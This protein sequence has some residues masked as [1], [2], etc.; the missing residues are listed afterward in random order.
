[1]SKIEQNHRLAHPTATRKVTAPRTNKTEE[2][3]TDHYTPS[4]MAALP[5]DLGRQL[6]RL[7][8]PQNP[9]PALGPDDHPTVFFTL[10]SGQ[11]VKAA[12]AEQVKEISQ[13][14]GDGQI[15]K[16]V[17]QG[18]GCNSKQCLGSWDKSAR[19][20]FAL[21]PDGHISLRNSQDQ[22]IGDFAKLFGKKFRS[23]HSTIIF[24][25]C[26]TAQDNQKNLTK[27]TSEAMPGVRVIGNVNEG[28]GWGHIFKTGQDDAT[29]P[30]AAGGFS[31]E[32]REY[33]NDPRRA[34]HHA[35][36]VDFHTWQVLR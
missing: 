13:R 25:G 20:G 24:Q 15:I 31:T 12:T 19:Q 34:N 2:K 23:E 28:W 4:E 11:V 36:L 16:M 21:S 14:V 26:Y 17:A 18:H 7:C 33:Y 10:A 5:K 9:Q 27:G 6:A 8:L 32:A 3:P 22:E 1:M 30:T 35:R 29:P